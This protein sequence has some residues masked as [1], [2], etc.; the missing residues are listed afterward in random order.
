MIS[1]GNLGSEV[2]TGGVAEGDDATE[3]TKPLLCSD[4]QE[5][6]EV[7]FL[8]FSAGFLSFL[9]FS[10]IFSGVFSVV[11]VASADTFLSVL[12]DESIFSG[13]FAM[14]GVYELELSAIKS[15]PW[16]YREV[17]EH[18][19]YFRIVDIGKRNR[20]RSVFG[21]RILFLVNF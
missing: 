5:S 12:E 10:G 17:I 15:H 3:E 13:V 4:D 9:A 8:L 7:F 11:F 18:P 14:S 6:R 20:W 1:G 19:F 21:D 16:R 2:R